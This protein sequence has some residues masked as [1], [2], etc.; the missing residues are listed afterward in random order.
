LVHEIET[1]SLPSFVAQ[2]MQELGK[3]PSL[4][5]LS[6]ESGIGVMTLQRNFAGTT[7]MNLHTAKQLA[8]F[9]DTTIDE[10]ISN[11]PEIL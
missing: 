5:Q 1:S 10:L 7:K 8:D 4:R 11:V 2:R 6:S 3:R 9:L